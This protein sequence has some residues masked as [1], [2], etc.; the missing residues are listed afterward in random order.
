MNDEQDLRDRFEAIPVPPT[1]VTVDAL[2][3][4]GRRRAFR[5][6]SW[7][8]AGGVALATGL[9]VA[10]PTMVIGD[11]APPP[12]V[13]VAPTTSARPTPPKACQ[14]TILR[15]PAGVTD[16][17][18]SGVDPSGRYIIGYHSKGQNFLP[19]L[20]TD[21]VP[22]KLPLVAPSTQLTSVNR[23]GVVAGLAEGPNF[24]YA[25][26]YENGRYTR[27]RTPPGMDWIYPYPT[28]NS[29]GDIVINAKP[30]RASGSHSGV[31]LLYK[32]G[33]STPITLPLP[34]NANVYD[35]TDDG[36]I[37]GGLQKDGGA[38]SAYAWDRNGR[39]RKL[40][41][42]PGRRSMVYSAEGDWATGGLWPEDGDATP[43][44]WDLRTGK[45]TQL[46]TAEGPGLAVN[47]DGWVLA[48]NKLVRDGQEA[49]LP[50]PPDQEIRALGVSDTGL[51]VGH[52]VTSVGNTIVAPHAWQC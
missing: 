4:A 8:A 12:T 23:N 10:V 27:L 25:F 45:L 14:D 42:V 22:R 15:A 50:I 3:E 30:P 32:A 39:S 34:T 31:S 28:M 20:W 51:V 2:V 41:S 44:L 5:R 49:P 9:L 37:V 52:A 17:A 47:D 16:V 40:E 21:G 11:P 48:D 46:R 1:R 13:V 35:I 24:Q 19:L 43:A 29:A 36:T 7:Q 18:A 33:S 38:D 6:R 26:R